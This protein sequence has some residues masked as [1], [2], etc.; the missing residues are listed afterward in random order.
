MAATEAKIADDFL[1][2]PTVLESYRANFAFDLSASLATVA[3]T[4]RASG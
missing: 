3:P 4:G 1:A 2:R